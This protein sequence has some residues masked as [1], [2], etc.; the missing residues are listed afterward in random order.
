MH[1]LHT[2]SSFAMCSVHARKTAWQ[3][4]Q[5]THF[6]DCKVVN[7]STR[8][9][10]YLIPVSF[11]WSSNH[12]R[13]AKERD[14]R[15]GSPTH[16]HFDHQ[17]MKHVFCVFPEDQYEMHSHMSS[18]ALD[19]C[20]LGARWQCLGKHVLSRV[21]LDLYFLHR[22]YIDIILDETSQM[23][24][25]YNTMYIQNFSL[26]FFWMGSS[27]NI[28]SLTVWN[29]FKHNEKV[30]ARFTLV[31]HFSTLHALQHFYI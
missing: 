7:T 28:L 10:R 1:A 16:M 27:R 26:H 21:F 17:I 13:R 8:K 18:Q 11:S 20:T 22:P 31:T 19:I 12:A 15:I 2:V 3:W 4:R 23:Y 5:R 14:R 25:I 29:A 24:Q 30:H 6:R 9:V